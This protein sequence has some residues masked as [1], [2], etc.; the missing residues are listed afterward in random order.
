MIVHARDDTLVNPTH[1][2]YAARKI[3]DAKVITL[4]SGGHLLMGQHDRVRTEIVK[5]LRQQCC[6]WSTGGEVNNMD[7]EKEKVKMDNWHIWRY[8]GT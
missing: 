4:E 2:Q 3:P 8:A 5:F 6:D 7:Q 1:S